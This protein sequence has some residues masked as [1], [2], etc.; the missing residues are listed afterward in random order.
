M[1]I[2]SR[3]HVIKTNLSIIEGKYRYKRLAIISYLY[4]HITAAPCFE[5]ARSIKSGIF[6]R[7][8]NP[9]FI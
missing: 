3:V 7:Y 5:L 6:N 2:P 9:I 8:F 4:Q 1:L